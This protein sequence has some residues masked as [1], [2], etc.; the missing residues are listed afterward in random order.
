MAS[1]SFD[2][3]N[4]H[5]NCLSWAW[6]LTDVNSK[7]LGGDVVI[8]MCSP[9]YDMLLSEKHYFHQCLIFSLVNSSDYELKSVELYTFQFPSE[10]NQLIPV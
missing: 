8:H 9:T 3:L 10:G 1:S 4:K 6:N 7:F 5:F 2:V